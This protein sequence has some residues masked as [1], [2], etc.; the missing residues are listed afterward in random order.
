M[1]CYHA[2]FTCRTR[3]NKCWYSLTSS[4]KSYIFKEEQIL[5]CMLIPQK[6][7]DDTVNL[8][9]DT[10]E[11]KKQAL[12]FVGSKR[13]AEK[14]AEEIAKKCVTTQ[15]E[16]GEKVLHALIK[17]TQQCERLAKGVEKGIAFHH[18]GLHSKQ[19][20]LVEDNFRSGN[21]K[22]IC[23][24]P[25]LCLSKDTMIWHDIHET[26]VSNLKHFHQLFVLS[27]PKLVSIKFQKVQKIINA[28]SLVKISSVSGYSIK[29]TS[30][31]KMMIKRSKK[32]LLIEAKNI[33]KKDKIA[34][35]GYLNIEKTRNPGIKE[36][37]HD[38]K[39]NIDNFVFNRDLA[40]FI[41]VMLGDGYSGA[42]TNNN[43]I[44]YKGSPCIVGRDEEVFY[45]AKKVADE[46]KISAKG[47]KNYHGTPQL[48]LG[49]NK[50][51]RE[52]LVRCGIE[53]REYKHI[54]D[55]LM[56]MNLECTASLLQGLFDTDGW[57]QKEK[58]IGFS[59][60]SETLIKQ[61]QKL[62]LRFGI[63]SR[64]RKRKAGKMQIYNKEYATKEQWEIIITQKKNILDFYKY[65]NFIMIYFLV[66]QKNKRSGEK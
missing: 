2:F 51:F 28:S 55:K 34:T 49:K 63:V 22:I 14:Q 56:T 27:Y 19:R 36:F 41:G 11:K 18:A 42:E 50:W 43:K 66:E 52:F 58:E 37:I 39:V 9:L 7:K 53:H 5:N 48:I 62:L 3:H 31:H 59:N 16:L 15:T 23:S 10:I 45:N 4:Y 30:N 1:E 29:V 46:L 61:M 12:I 60:I 38:N 20:E 26:E 6:C 13:S 21:I 17:P 57:I 65:I 47:S 8:A 40:Y 64:I 54:N 33:K 24:T 32:K 25:T 35:V 44:R